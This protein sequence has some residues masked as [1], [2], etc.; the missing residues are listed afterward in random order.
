MM[1]PA[2]A[3]TLTAPPKGSVLVLAPHP[4]DES[5]GCGG[6]VALHCLQGDQVKVVFATDGAAGD[7][8]GHYANCD[9]R[10]VRRAEARKAGEILG[11]RDLVFWEYQ[12]GKLSGA[13]DLADRLGRLL[14]AERPDLIYRPS[15]R[16]VHPDHWA[17]A[18]A[19]DQALENYQG[20]VVAYAYEIWAAVQPTHVLDITTVWDVKCKA[21]EQYDSQLRY[22]DYLHKISGLNAY[23]AIYLPSARYVEAFEAG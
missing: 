9:Y 18:K 21:I 2:S 22:N 11:V 1:P 16:E 23:R 15:V 6:D 3:V 7:P 4:D 10:E 12:D 13:E 19:V 5:L 20:R 17:L 14:T 8:L